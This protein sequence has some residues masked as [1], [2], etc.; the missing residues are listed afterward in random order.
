LR[1]AATPVDGGI[2]RMVR[3]KISGP[4]DG[5]LEQ[6]M[7]IG[8]LLEVALEQFQECHV[9]FQCLAGLHLGVLNQ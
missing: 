5:E 4:P 8:R 6:G 1:T 2:C 3:K 7:A 9:P